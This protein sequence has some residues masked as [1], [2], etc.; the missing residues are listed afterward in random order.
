[1]KRFLKVFC[2]FL[3]VF[4]FC[5]GIISA[6]SLEERLKSMVSSNAEMY[7]NPLVTAFGSGMNSGWFH[8]AKPHKLLGFDIGVRAM[9][10]TFPDDQKIFEFDISQLSDYSFST[11][12]STYSISLTAADLYPNHEVPTFFGSDNF[13]VNFPSSLS[14]AVIFLWVALTTLVLFCHFLIL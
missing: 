2:V 12:I 14:A 9:M 5:A 7:V 3:I 13:E 1:M 4:A 11:L 8:S 10:V 6:Q